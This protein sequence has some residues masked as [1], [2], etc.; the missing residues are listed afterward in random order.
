LDY[1]AHADALVRHL[2]ITPFLDDLS[3][4]VGDVDRDVWAQVVEQAGR[5]AEAVIAPLNPVL[6]REGARVCDG[7]VRTSPGHREAWT[8]FAQG[9]WLGLPLP[10]AVG[11]WRCRWCCKAPARSCSTAPPRLCDAGDAG[12]HGCGFAE[13]QRCHG[14]RR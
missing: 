4:E 1:Q 6:D 3:R 10:E 7:R 13:D 14:S 2:E 11:A 12:P 9:G 8:H 5:V